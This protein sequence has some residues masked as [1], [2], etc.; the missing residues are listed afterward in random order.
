MS[1]E[2]VVVIQEL[3]KKVAEL[4]RQ[5]AEVKANPN[6]ERTLEDESKPKKRSYTK[7]NTGENSQ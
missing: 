5:L 1:Y 7:R 6:V 2:F 3:E 4:E